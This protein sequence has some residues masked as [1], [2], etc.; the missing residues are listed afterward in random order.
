MHA[1]DRPTFPEVVSEHGEF[2]QRALSQLGVCARDLADV[3]QEVRRGIDRGL[4]TYDPSLAKNPESAMRGWLF[5]ICER[6]AASHRRSESRR[7]EILLANE[8]LDLARSTA[9]S[10]EEKLLEAERKALLAGLLA[11]LEPLRRAVIVA[12]E[13]LGISM[14]EIAA[15]MSIPVNTAWNRLR[16]AREDLRAAYYRLEAQERG[17]L[18]RKGMQ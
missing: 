15:G 6:Q 5:G 1:P 4:P 16:L 9:P 12:Y 10:A 18:F 14:Q 7:K 3:A 17:A 8:D 2:I 13:L 11:T